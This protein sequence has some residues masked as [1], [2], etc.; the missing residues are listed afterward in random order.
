MENRDIGLIIGGSIALA[1]T[2]IGLAIYGIRKMNKIVSNVI[3]C[4]SGYDGVDDLEEVKSDDELNGESDEE[5]NTLEVYS[6]I[7]DNLW[8]YAN[9]LDMR[10][11]KLQESHIELKKGQEETNRE[12]D[13]LKKSSE[14]RDKLKKSQ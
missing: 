13:E 12:L 7:L 1:I 5:H 14:E 2:A 10:V 11:K 9:E 4:T 6:E 3:E 8:K